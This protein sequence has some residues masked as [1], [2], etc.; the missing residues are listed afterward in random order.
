MGNVNLLAVFLAATAFFAVGALWY[1]VLF[2][3]PWQRETGITEPPQGAQ[4]A[5]I[6]GLTFAF[7]LLVCLMLGHNIARTNPA[8]HVIMMMA[9]GFGLTIMT[10]AIGINYLHQRKSLTLFLIDAGHFVVGMAVVGGVFVAF[11]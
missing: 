2:G 8:P 6:M 4:V 7:E 5:K 10:P 3:K 9:V 1:G 11:A